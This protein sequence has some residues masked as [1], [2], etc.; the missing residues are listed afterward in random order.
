LILAFL[1]SR[2][3]GYLIVALLVVASYGAAYVK[4]RMD[5]DDKRDEM[6]KAE[7]QEADKQSALLAGRRDKVTVQVVTKYVDRVKVIQ[8]ETVYVETLRNAP[9]LPSDFRLLHDRAAGQVPPTTSRVDAAAEVPLAVAAQT[10]ADNYKTCRLNAEQLNS[11][12]EWVTT[13][14]N[15]K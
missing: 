15:L 14:R 6:A 3:G 8:G 10:I 12:Q 2:L 13:Q 7:Q 5:N 11:L 4:G 1:G 9:D